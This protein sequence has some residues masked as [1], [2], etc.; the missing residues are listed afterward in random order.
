[1]RRQLRT[2]ST[3]ETVPPVGSSSGPPGACITPSRLTNAPTTIFRMTNLP[4]DMTS[5]EE[6]RSRHALAHVETNY[7]SRVMRTDR[8]PHSDCG[9]CLR[10][11]D[12][13]SDGLPFPDNS[14]GL[15]RP[16]EPDIEIQG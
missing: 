2:Q 14:A 11:R 3:P 8:S 16:E 13:A 5:N 15:H 1:M 6:C 12:H 10:E 4:S 9:L 7:L